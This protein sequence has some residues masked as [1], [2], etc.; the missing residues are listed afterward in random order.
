MTSPVASLPLTA[1]GRERERER[2]GGRE[3]GRLFA[4][5]FS[6]EPLLGGASVEGLSGPCQQ[7]LMQ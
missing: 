4:Q 2:E 5:G 3:G 1:L 7:P 6:R